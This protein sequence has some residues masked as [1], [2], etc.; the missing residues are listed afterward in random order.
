[1]LGL[2]SFTPSPWLLVKVKVFLQGPYSSGSMLTTLATANLIPLSQ[3]STSASF[4]YAGSETAA[5]TAFLQTNSVVDWI[6]VEL[7][8]SAIGAA[9]DRHAALLKS[10]GTT[11]VTFTTAIACDYYIL[12][13]QHNNLAVM[14]TPVVTLP[15]ASVCNFTT[16]LTQAYGSTTLMVAV[17]I[18]VYGMWCGDTDASGVID[19]TDRANTWNDRNKTGLYSGNEIHLSNVIYVTDRAN[20]WNNRNLVIQVS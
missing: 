13:K 5:S 6:L 9:G 11:G 2:A 17:T 3:P 8:S 18:K 4:S 15:N 12:I 19:V 7:R 10:D 1:L 16:V 20:T 14:S